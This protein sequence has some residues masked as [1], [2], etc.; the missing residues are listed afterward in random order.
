L[1]LLAL[2]SGA[3]RGELAGLTVADV[4][5]EEH[6]RGW[7]L[8]FNPDKERGKKLKTKQSERMVPLHP[9]LKRLEFLEFVDEAKRGG[10]A[11]AWLFAA[12]SP[13]SKDGAKA[14]SKWFGRYLRSIG[15]TDTRKVFHSFRHNFIDA[16]RSAGVSEELNTALVGHSAGG[17]V[18]RSYGAK[19]MVHRFG[20]QLA[21]AVASVRYPKLDLS[22][23]TKDRSA[24]RRPAA[25][26]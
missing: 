24:A 6:T 25:K 1:P 7:V 4:K 22:H 15:I 23:L 21:K 19:E 13:R 18:H 16:L 11:D 5:K 14:W 12:I 3:R 26:R 9:E 2:F 8:S 10:G 20:P 17:S